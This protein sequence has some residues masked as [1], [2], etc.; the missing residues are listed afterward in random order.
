MASSCDEANEDAFPT[1]KLEAVNHALLSPLTV[2]LVL[3][4]GDVLCELCRVGISSDL[5]LQDPI[6]TPGEYEVQW[7]R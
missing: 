5:D 4:A 2:K 1:G 3:E 6:P 7:R